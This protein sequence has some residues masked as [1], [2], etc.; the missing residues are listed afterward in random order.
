MR[1][2]GLA[3]ALWDAGFVLCISL[4][5]FFPAKTSFNVLPSTQG[6]NWNQLFQLISSKVKKTSTPIVFKTI[7]SPMLILIHNVH[8]RHRLFMKR[9]MVGEPWLPWPYYKM[10]FLGDKMYHNGC[11]VVYVWN[12][13][14]KNFLCLS[15][16]VQVFLV[17]SPYCPKKLASCVSMSMTRVA[18]SRIR[19][20]VLWT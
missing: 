18:R 1:W 14:C 12:A 5:F 6:Q 13:L 19:T 9:K 17:F 8:G 10:H 7:V 20:Y 4:I 15:R 2:V 11:R 16:F 3:D